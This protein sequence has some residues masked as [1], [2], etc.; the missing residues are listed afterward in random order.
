MPRGSDGMLTILQVLLT[1]YILSI[2]VA[3]PFTF[4]GKLNSELSDRHCTSHIKSSRPDVSGFNRSPEG[5]VPHVSAH[6]HK[7]MKVELDKLTVPTE[8]ISPVSGIVSAQQFYDSIQTELT[9]TQLDASSENHSSKDVGLLRE[10]EFKYNLLHDTVRNLA[11]TN[12][13]ALRGELNCTQEFGSTL[14]TRCDNFD[15]ILQ[16]E[17]M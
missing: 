13:E 12:L 5:I 3:P 16:E 6:P 17:R 10:L 8:V 14:T 11:W 2:N 9:E 4:G 1:Q 15:R 7:P